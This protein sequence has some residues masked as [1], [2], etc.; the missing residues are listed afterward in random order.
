M[1]ENSVIIVGTFE[2]LHEK[3]L[4]YKGLS[5]CKL[6]VIISFPYVEF[7]ESDVFH[8]HICLQHVL[9]RWFICFRNFFKHNKAVVIFHCLSRRTS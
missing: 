7:D 4:L 6:H 5:L 2:K 3:G 1:F 8:R 9:S